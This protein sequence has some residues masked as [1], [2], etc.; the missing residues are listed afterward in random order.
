M[1]KVFR[2]E[3]GVSNSEKNNIVLIFFAKFTTPDTA[4]TRSLL[5]FF[6]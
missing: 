6:L 4:H 1:E 3:E 5:K 2:L